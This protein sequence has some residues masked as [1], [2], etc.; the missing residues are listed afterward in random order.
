MTNIP[1]DIRQKGYADADD[2]CRMYGRHRYRYSKRQP[3]DWYWD[4]NG[5]KLFNKAQLE[6]IRKEVE[7]N[8]KEWEVRRKK[9]NEYWDK[10][11][12]NNSVWSADN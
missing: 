7:A 1:E 12:A 4:I 9:E 10:I 8:D 6:R 5:G 3:G 2:L 11:N